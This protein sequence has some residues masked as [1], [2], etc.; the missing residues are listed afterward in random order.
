MVNP[1][2]I[3]QQ[4]ES[5]IVY[6][7]TAALKGAITI[8]KGRVQQSNFDNYD[9]LRIDEMPKVEVHIVESH[10]APGGVGEAMCRQSRL[11]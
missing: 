10:E 9:M 1:S 2:I 4:V 7:L 11:R 8:D 3:K 5:G 6:G